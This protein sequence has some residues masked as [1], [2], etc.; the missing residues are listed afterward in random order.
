M[1][2]RKRGNVHLK[3]LLDDIQA[4]W[5]LHLGAAALSIGSA[6]GIVKLFAD[7]LRVREGLLA[8][9]VIFL[10]LEWSVLYDVVR[11]IGDQVGEIARGSG[12]CSLIAGPTHAKMIKQGGRWE[13][14]GI[15]WL[16]VT[17]D[18]GSQLHLTLRAPP[19]VRLAWRARGAVPAFW[20]RDGINQEDMETWSLKIARTEGGVTPLGQFSLRADT[21]DAT[22]YS[23]VIVSANGAS[24]DRVAISHEIEIGLFGDVPAEEGFRPLEQ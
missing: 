8:G 10:I 24:T 16:G 17:C 14:E 20:S 11:R 15:V 9:A 12:S 13:S 22:A 1:T 5:P 6:W 21:F 18:T 4:A 2:S 19:A 3:E 7:E 23:R